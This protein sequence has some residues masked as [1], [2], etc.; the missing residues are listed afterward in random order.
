MADVLGVV[1]ARDGDYAMVR[2][3]EVGGCG[4]CHEPGGCGG[5]NVGKALS[6]ELRVF[7][8]FNPAC[9]G[10]GERVVVAAAD[11]VVRRSAFLAY[12]LPLFFLLVWA[13]LGNALAGDVGSIFGALFGLLL[14]W[15]AL[16][17]RGTH[18]QAEPF[19]R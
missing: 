14:A 4:R 6:A 18:G 12:G 17:F 11:G 2:M 1:V 15:F 3:D 9:I 19:I 16:R 13:C 8:V 7:R 5:G 10:V